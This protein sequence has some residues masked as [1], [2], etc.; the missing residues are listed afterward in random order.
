MPYINKQSCKSVQVL[1]LEAC[2]LHEI[3]HKIDDYLLYYDTCYFPLIHKNCFE[4]AETIESWLLTELGNH[5]QYCETC[6]GLKIHVQADI[7]NQ[8]I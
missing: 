7:N 1:T 6:V 5:E 2:P 8:N 3:I 4:T